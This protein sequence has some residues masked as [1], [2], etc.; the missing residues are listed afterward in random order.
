MPKC[1]LHFSLTLC[2]SETEWDHQNSSQ[3]I[4]K[5]K[6]VHCHGLGEGYKK[7][8][9]R[10]QL[11]ISTVRNVVREWKDTGTVA[12]KPRSSR[13]RKVQERHMRRIVRMVAHNPKITSKDLQ[14]HLAADCVSVHGSTIQCN[15]HQNI[16][17]ARW[18]EG[19]PFCAHATDTVAWSMQKLI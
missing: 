11:S 3:K 9:Q 2:W 19:S 1:K 14:E 4:W 18:W 7:L 8:S 15:L 17:M 12:V 13:P 5:T 6:I 16:C 10:F